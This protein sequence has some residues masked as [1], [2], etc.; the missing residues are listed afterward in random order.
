MEHVV[1]INAHGRIE[2]FAEKLY[3][4]QHKMH[5]QA[6]SVWISRLHNGQR[7]FLLQRRAFSKYH[8]GGLWANTCCGH[9]RPGEHVAQGAHRRLREELG[10]TN[11]PLRFLKSWNYLAAVGSG[12][13]ENE[14]T[15]VFFGLMQNPIIVMNIEEVMDY[16]W[17][18][19]ADIERLYEQNPTV[20]SAWFW[21]VFCVL[22]QDA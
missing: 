13:H 14:T 6:F 18:N 8:S 17:C 10:I 12:L 2:G 11:T 4:H 9:P 7:E 1:L 21:G 5:H 15:Y 20:F 19:I 3:A 22:K 16:Q